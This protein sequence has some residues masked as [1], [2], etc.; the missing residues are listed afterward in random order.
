MEEG[1]V[2]EVLTSDE[3]QTVA[4]VLMMD[5]AQQWL[6]A[7]FIIIVGL[8]LAKFLTRAL[9]LALESLMGAD[10]ATLL[11]RFVFYGLVA[12]V[13][14]AAL[15]E[16]GFS[17][18]VILGAAGILTVAVG[19]A[20]QTSASNLISGIFL[21]TE[22][23]FKLGDAIKVGDIT[24]E[25]LSIDLLS[26]KLRQYDNIYVRVPNETLIKSNISNLTHFPIRRL[27]LQIGVAYKEQ[28]GVV[29]ELLMEVANDF[30]L[31][32]DQPEPLVIF[33][34][35]GDSALNLQ[36]SVWAERTNFL[37]LRNGMPERIKQ[38][39][40]EKGIEI[41]FPHVSL[42]VGSQTGPLPIILHDAKDKSDS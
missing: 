28:I 1:I 36:F 17:L 6:R 39:F 22:K 4:D 20:A 16:L 31:C 29:R 40:D 26:V 25:V 33:Q 23:S 18:S 3:V 24:G 34:G 41:P 27:D 30:P 7:L 15:R 5:V 11:R 37:A 32:L 42:Y 38:A 12:V 21:V 9:Y 10:T 2:S 14:M 19:F 8:V 13:V 35:F